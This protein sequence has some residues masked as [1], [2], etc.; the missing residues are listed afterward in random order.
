MLS[1]P[2]TFWRSSHPSR[3]TGS[4]VEPSQCSAVEVSA[5]D[6]P[7]DIKEGSIS[8][9]RPAG[10]AVMMSA[11]SGRRV[12]RPLS[13]RLTAAVQGGPKLPL[14][15]ASQPSHNT[16]ESVPSTVRRPSVGTRSSGDLLGRKGVQASA[17]NRSSAAAA[18]AIVA[19]AADSNSSASSTPRQS[20]GDTILHGLAQQA[21]QL[22]CAG[23]V[24]Q[25][26]DLQS[27][28]ATLT[29]LRT[30][31]GLNLDLLFETLL[32]SRS[33]PTESAATTS[34]ESGA[35]VQQ[36]PVNMRLPRGVLGG[37]AKQPSV[38]ASDN[39]I[40]IRLLN[41]HEKSSDSVALNRIQLHDANEQQCASKLAICRVHALVLRL[42]LWIVHDPSCLLTLPC[43][44]TRL[45]VFAGSP[46]L[47]RM[48]PSATA[49]PT[50]TLRYL[51]W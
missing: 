28:V 26:T 32:E 15:P 40:V 12:S 23:S 3:A 39:Q 16:T 27:A 45:H 25:G 14:V 5:D 34:V 13:N 44:H 30:Q 9:Q 21:Q 46:C 6:I 11:G 47:P 1:L 7:E 10:P 31:E 49:H 38:R 48:C 17:G 19:A 29:K 8:P 36:R 51:Y 42:C 2:S 33:L 20:D 37:A 50:N 35:A 4:L 43:F 22:Q 41:P 24:Q 18:A